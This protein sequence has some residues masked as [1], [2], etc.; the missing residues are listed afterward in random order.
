M[1]LEDPVGIDDFEG[2]GAVAR[3]T[4]TP[5]ASGENLGTFFAFRDLVE[6]PLAVV[7]A[8]PVCVGGVTAMRRVAGLAQIH[9][10]GFAGHDCGGPV[11][12]AVDVHVAMHAQNA[13]IQ[14]IS[15]ANYFTWYNEVA[16]GMPPIA[17]GRIRPTGAAGHGVS[18]RDEFRTNP[19][20]EVYEARHR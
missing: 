16:T 3:S 10:R 4:R 20:T 12:L 8:E 13:V 9:M 14:E 1:W 7:I 2:L 18:L 5:V 11:S 19:Q 15:R 17:N 6:Q